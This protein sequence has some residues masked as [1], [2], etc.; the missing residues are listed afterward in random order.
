MSNLARRD[1]RMAVVAALGTITGLT[2]VSPGVWDSVPST[3]PEAKVR[4]LVD[5]KTST[6]RHEPGF[7][8]VVTLQVKLAVQNT[9][10]E[11]AQDDIEALGNLVE[12]A[13]LG[14]PALVGQIQQFPQVVTETGVSTDGALPIGW[15][16]LMLDVET[17]EHFDQ[18]VLGTAP[19]VPLDTVQATVKA[20][21][22]ADA[23]TLVSNV[24]P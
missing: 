21:G 24:N 23:I 14:S 3:F 13:V 16:V 4:V 19:A 7:T 15:A 22:A 1:I 18:V 20:D 6:G 8:T 9:T 11:A 2:V 12:I 10:A 17:F 5:R